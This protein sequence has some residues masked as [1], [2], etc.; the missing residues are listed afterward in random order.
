[1]GL[2]GQHLIGNR[3][4]AASAKTFHASNP[5]SGERLEPAF[6]E[7]TAG[8]VDA[9][10]GLADAAFVVVRKKGAH[11]RAGLLRAIAAEIL[12]L[13]DALVVR[14][15]EETGLPRPRI[16]G[17]RGR[18][19]GQ[20]KMFA[21][22][23]E[24]G[25]W[26]DARI[27]RAQPERQPLPKPDVRRM[28]VALGPVAVFGASNFPLAFSVA[29]GDTA[30]ALA[31]GCP[32]VCK[33]HP[34]H[35][36]TSE[37]VAGAIAKAVEQTGFPAATFALLQGA[38]V[39]V[40]TALV[41]HPAIR[42]VG[43]TGS[44]KAGR[45]LYDMAARRP[46][47][48]PVHAEMGS[49]NPVFVL[50]GALKERG[51]A[52]AQ[53]LIGSVTMG[54]GQFCTKPGLVFLPES[55]DGERFSEVVAAALAAVAPGTMLHAGIRANFQGGAKRLSG[56]AGVQTKVSPAAMAT[57][58]AQQAAMLF[59]TTAAELAR[60]PEIAE[61]LFGPATVAVT[62]GNREELLAAARNLDGHLTATLHATPQDLAEYADL[63]DVLQTKV[64]RLILNGWPTGVEVCAAMHHGGPYPA[65]TDARTTSVGTA[66]IYRWAKPLCFQNFPNDAL[67]EELRDGNPR[68]IWRQVDGRLGRE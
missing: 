18:T 36:G 14:T 52:I 44:L 45:A 27:D 31:A 42:A 65:T 43:F 57:P 34:A 8:E 46:H 12:N 55:A 54:V 50:P 29:G 25:S 1:M 48:I 24:E 3:P 58:G 33:G 11:D 7:A 13:G 26:V 30:S 68:G 20:L 37:L 15:M 61:E 19:V 17:E 6:Y 56:V 63:V 9:A 53:G 51:E 66:A 62:A 28:L 67:P 38:G 64:G 49:T 59:Q 60:S 41:Q 23:V 21:D 4:A 39:E 5:A 47:P 40:G 35:P 16:E 32:V 2:H 10:C 22:L